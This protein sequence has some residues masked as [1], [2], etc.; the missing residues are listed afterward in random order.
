MK[1]PWFINVF[2]LQISHFLEEYP[3]NLA[4]IH[5]VLI[6]RILNSSIPLPSY[7]HQ[8][9]KT[10]ELLFKTAPTL[11]NAKWQKLRSSLLR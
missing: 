9:A 2:D 11:Y 1:E 8:K 4:L 7:F 3:N 10:L 6:L 5:Y